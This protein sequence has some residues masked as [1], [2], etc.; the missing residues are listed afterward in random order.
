MPISNFQSIPTLHPSPPVTISSFSMKDLYLNADKKHQ[1]GERLK[2]QMRNGKVI[3]NRIP[4][5]QGKKRPRD[6]VEIL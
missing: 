2:M 1:G 6:P 3:N 4:E 5:S